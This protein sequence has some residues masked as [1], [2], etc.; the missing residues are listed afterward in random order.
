MLLKGEPL[1]QQPFE[2]EENVVRE[3]YG[4]LGETDHQDGRWTELAGLESCPESW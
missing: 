4:D 3:K 1:T 2:R